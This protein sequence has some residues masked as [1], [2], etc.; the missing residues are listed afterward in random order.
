MIQYLYGKIPETQ[1]NLF[2]RA[3]KEKMSVTDFEEAL[4]L[5]NE[6]KKA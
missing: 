5:H 3:L 2:R 6:N 4:L 1:A